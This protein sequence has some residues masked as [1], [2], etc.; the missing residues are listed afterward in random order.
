[1]LVKQED[2]SYL[3]TTVNVYEVV[4][5]STDYTGSNVA[6]F[7]QAVDDALQV[8]EYVQDNSIPE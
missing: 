8:I 5:N 1:M 2:G 3:P 6:A 4:F 7:S